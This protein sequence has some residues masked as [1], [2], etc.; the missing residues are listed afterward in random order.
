MQ[1]KDHRRKERPTT[2]CEIIHTKGGHER[3]LEVV[4]SADGI[5]QPSN[6]QFG[7]PDNMD[8][9]EKSDFVFDDVQLSGMYDL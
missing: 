7:S 3:D 1:L 5:I 9:I 8:C 4:H 2:A 6:G